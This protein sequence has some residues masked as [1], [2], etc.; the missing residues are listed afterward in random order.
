MNRSIKKSE[1][2]LTDVTNKINNVSNESLIYVDINDC[3]IFNDNTLLNN[4]LFPD[5]MM[6]IES[7]NNFILL[8]LNKEFN[9]T[10]GKKQKVVQSKS[11]KKQVKQ[12]GNIEYDKLVDSIKNDSLNVNNIES[13][14]CLKIIQ[15]ILLILIHVNYDLFKNCRVFSVTIANCLFNFKNHTESD[16][17]ECTSYSKFLEKCED[18]SYQLDSYLIQD[19]CRCLIQFSVQRFADN[20][21]GFKDKVK[22][23]KNSFLYK[24]LAY[25]ERYA[26]LLET[27]RTKEF[28]QFDAYDKVLL[29]KALCDELI[30]SECF[31]TLVEQVRVGEQLTDLNANILDIQSEL[32]PIG[33]DNENSAYWLFKSLPNKIVRELN[34][35]WYEY[36][37]LNDKNEPSDEL[38]AVLDHLQALKSIELRIKIKQITRDLIQNISIKSK[39]K[40]NRIKESTSGN[41]IN[42]Q[43]PI[44]DLYINI[45]KY[46]KKLINKGLVKNS[47]YYNE[48]IIAYQNGLKINNTKEKFDFMVGKLRY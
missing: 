41:I 7:Y 33:F 46:H 44:D 23:N 14:Y 29:L 30:A 13:D 38:F 8:Y 48:W 28:S 40:R 20:E 21:A 26:E 16:Y 10:I 19:L 2:S 47:L 43:R 3:L 5:I 35:K 15:N 12:F 1:S 4:Q 36:D 27:L 18:F 31:E 6:I 45:G 22:F 9:M 37:I 34:D 17:K 32:V 24:N 11:Y 39:L 42:N 25:E